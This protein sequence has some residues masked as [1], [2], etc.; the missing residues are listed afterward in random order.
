[1]LSLG[2]VLAVVD[3]ITLAGAVAQEHAQRVF[4]SSD[5]K[6]DLGAIQLRGKT[7]YISWRLLAQGLIVIRLCPQM[8]FRL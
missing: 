4:V 1:M 7:A 3:P 8:S 6:L 2:L 5:T